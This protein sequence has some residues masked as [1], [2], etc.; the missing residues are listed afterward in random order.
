MAPA[1]RVD[2]FLAS[3][4]DLGPDL[5]PELPEPEPE[6]E[7]DLPGLYTK[8]PALVLLKS[9]ARL[10]LLPPSWDAPA[11][12]ALPGPTRW[13]TSVIASPLRWIPDEE[14]QDQ[15]WGLASTRLSERCGRTGNPSPL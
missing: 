8:P 2:S 7:L 5:E 11:P 12:T 3:R 13:L 1:L 4:P 9:L 14:T 6:P 15:I 10:A